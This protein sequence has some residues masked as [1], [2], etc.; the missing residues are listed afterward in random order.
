MTRILEEYACVA[1]EGYTLGVAGILASAGK[2]ELRP[3]GSWS[4]EA[5]ASG[6]AEK[7]WMHGWLD[8]ADEIDPSTL[9]ALLLEWQARDAPGP[10][11]G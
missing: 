8:Q 7:D 11:R 10:R 3:D 2:S 1:R 9:A 6:L 5:V 4:R